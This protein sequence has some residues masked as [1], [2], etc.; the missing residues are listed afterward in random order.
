MVVVYISGGEQ[1]AG[2]GGGDNKQLRFPMWA[3]PFMS[4]S[5]SLSL[6]YKIC[7]L[8][9]ERGVGG[10]KGKIQA[11]S[12][13]MDWLLLPLIA[14]WALR[15]GCDFSVLELLSGPKTDRQTYKGRISH[16]LLLLCLMRYAVTQ[17]TLA[18]FSTNVPSDLSCIAAFS[19][20]KLSPTFVNPATMNDAATA[21]RIAPTPTIADWRL[22]PWLPSDVESAELPATYLRQR[23]RD[24]FRHGRVRNPAL[25]PGFPLPLHFR[26]D[27]KHVALPR[28]IRVHVSRTVLGCIGIAAERSSLL[29]RRVL[30]GVAPVASSG[31]RA[32]GNLCGKTK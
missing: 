17:L 7:V 1:G 14:D 32:E 11:H 13:S 24:K 21:A 27:S 29:G 19:A 3:T 8:G 2:V 23:K 22:K 26:L 16:A 9:M 5:L 28:A 31:E 4:L 20:P 25:L 6:I 12:Q 18:N 30:G 15:G 10:G